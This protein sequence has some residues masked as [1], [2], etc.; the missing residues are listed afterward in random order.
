MFPKRPHKNRLLTKIKVQSWFNAVSIASGKTAYQLEKEFLPPGRDASNFPEKRSTIWQKYKSGKIEPSSNMIKGHTK[1][2]AE[3]VE[4]KYPG[5]IRWLTSPYWLLAD[6]DRQT[7]LEDL[8]YAYEWLHP[9]TRYLVVKENVGDRDIFWRKQTVERELLRKA[10]GIE[11]ID[12][13]TLAMAL[14][15]E[16]RLWQLESLYRGR[17]ENLMTVLEGCNSQILTPGMRSELREALRHIC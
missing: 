8:R 12:G 9:K 7:T 11:D 2:V 16:S 1:S 5:T 3:R 6:S 10:V 4:E 14:V 17:I 15:V 13:L